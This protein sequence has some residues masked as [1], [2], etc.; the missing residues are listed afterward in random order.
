MR[1]CSATHPPNLLD[2]NG[3]EALCYRPKVVCG[4]RKIATY[5]LRRRCTG[6]ILRRPRF[7]SRAFGGVVAQN[8]FSLRRQQMFQN[9]AMRTVRRK[10]LTVHHGLLLWD[11][12]LAPLA[13][14]AFCLGA[15][16]GLGFALWFRLALGFGLLF[17]SRFLSCFLLGRWS[18]ASRS[19]RFHG[20][21]VAFVALNR[22]FL[23]LYCSLRGPFGTLRFVFLFLVAGQLV[24]FF[25]VKF[26]VKHATL[27]N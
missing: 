18:G 21:L 19:R 10:R 15:L 27:R 25:V 1:L 2:D 24:I 12:Q 9:D 20:I 11:R 22:Y 13:L 23:D 4:K 26:S 8:L 5:E 14:A 16:L 6:L 17:W 7:D 3:H